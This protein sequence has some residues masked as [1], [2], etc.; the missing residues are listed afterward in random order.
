M[1]R[2]Y[3]TVE[4]F[5]HVKSWYVEGVDEADARAKALKAVG[6]RVSVTR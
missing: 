3:V 2:F 4:A 6:L 1:K 5:G